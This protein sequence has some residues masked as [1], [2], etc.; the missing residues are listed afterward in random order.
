MYA[1]TIWSFWH[2]VRENSKKWGVL[3]AVFFTIALGVKWT[4]AFIPVILVPW[5]IVIRKTTQFR[6]WFVPMRLLVFA[7]VACAICVA[8]LFAVSPFLW[9][10]TAGQLSNLFSFYRELGVSSEKV[11]FNSLPWYLFVGTTPEGILVFSLIAFFALSKSQLLLFFLWIFVPLFR[12]SLPGARFYG[13]INQ[14]M[15]VLPALAILAGVGA[16]YLVRISRG[17]IRKIIVFIIFILFI[18]L[19]IPLIRLHPN[20]NLYFNNLVGGIAG[21]RDRKLFDWFT[22]YGNLYKQAADWLNVH[23]QKDANIA[24][25]DG[26]T[27]ALSPLMVRPDI[28]ISP[29]HFSGF[30]AGGEYIVQVPDILGSYTFVARYTKKMLKPVHEI[31]VGGVTVL[32]I[33]KNDPKYWRRTI[34]EEK[35]E[36]PPGAPGESVNGPYWEIDLGKHVNVTRI[37]LSNIPAKCQKINSHFIDETIGFFDEPQAPINKKAVYTIQEHRLR[38]A[39]LLEYDFSGEPGRYVRIYI[40]SA[41]SCFLGARVA[42][43]SYISNNF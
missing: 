13:G 43:V 33:Y 31:R 17:V 4:I 11:G 3:V 10:D 23:A 12:L 8:I 16:D 15:E 9:H 21:A 26:P 1:G 40:E 7:C 39:D 27:F 22:N 6:R 25:L 20:E 5:L 30:D 34:A 37:V 41:M 19:I 18:L 36:N 42:W 24:H 2:W 32:E 38:S 28:S 35:I 29:Y 14:F